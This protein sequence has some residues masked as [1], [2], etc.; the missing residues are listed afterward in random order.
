MRMPHYLGVSMQERGDGNVGSQWAQ[1]SWYV[2]LFYSFTDYLCFYHLLDSLTMYHMSTLTTTTTT[3]DDDD[4]KYPLGDFFSFCF[5]FVYTF[6]RTPLQ[7]QLPS[8]TTRTPNT[9]RWRQLP[10]SHHHVTTSPPSPTVAMMMGQKGEM[11]RK[12]KWE[13]QELSMT[14][15]P[16]V[17]FFS[18]S[19]FLY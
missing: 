4:G 11:T 9:T 14:L 8:P 6:I 7:P 15:G 17:C 10:M 19:F 5:T 12:R 16:S 3:E 13:A 2:L 18:L 1:A